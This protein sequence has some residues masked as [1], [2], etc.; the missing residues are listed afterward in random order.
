MLSTVVA[1]NAFAPPAGW[2]SEAVKSV[3]AHFDESP[4]HTCAKLG[5]TYNATWGVCGTWPGTDVWTSPCD[6]APLKGTAGCDTSASFDDRAA[7]LVAALHTDE[8]VALFSNGAGAV[9]RLNIPKYQWWSEA[10]HGVGRSPGVTFDATTPNATSFPQVITTASSWNT[11]L[12]HAIG[13]VVGTEARAFS[14]LG[15]AGLTFWAPNVNIFRDPRW[16][17][18]QETQGEDPTVNA[19]YAANF[20]HGVQDGDSYPK[21]LKASS[22]C[23]H[24]AAYNLEDWGGVDRHHF[25]AIVTD[26]DLNE[27]YFPPFQACAQVGK[28]SG[29]MCSYNAVNGVPSCASKPLL[30][31]RL[32]GTWGFDGYVTSDCGAV[33]DVY[34]K[35]K[36]TNTTDATDVDVLTAGMDSDCGTFLGQNLQA[37]ID[38]GTCDASV[39][40][41]PLTNLF[42][43]Q[44]RLGMFDSAASQPYTKLGMESVSTP[45]HQALALEAAQQ[46]IVL[47]KND[48]ATLPLPKASP[49]TLAVLGPTANATDVMQGNYYGNAPFVVSVVAGLQKYTKSVAYVSGC[50]D[51]KCADDS[52]F[53]G[54]VMTA[55]A[56]E[57]VVLVVGLNQGQESEGHDRTD[58]A[59]PGK[60]AELI[61]QVAAA[62]KDPITLV[63]LSG[64]P[65]DV[66]A[67]KANAKVGAIVWAGYPGQSGGDALAQIIFGDVN[68]SARLTQTWYPAAFAQQVSMFDMGMR[69]NAT[70]GNPGR[71]YRFYTGTPVFAF[72]EGMSYSTF[73]YDVDNAATEARADDLHR[74]SEATHDDLTAAAALPAVVD[75]SVAVTNTG[76]RAGAETLITY[77]TPPAGARGALKRYVATFARVRLGAGETQE[78]KLPLTAAHFRFAAADGAMVTPAGKWV[79]EIEGSASTRAEHRVVLK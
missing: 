53:D 49:P 50:A 72:G 17:R 10:L 35:H 56:A 62:A 46:G 37:C 9:P 40:N 14:N 29:V 4:E 36:Y 27:T 43:V 59:L 78:V 54:A 12:F 41:P 70:S 8:K 30:N 63:I 24:Y 23:K 74:A 32:R 66:S 21:Y 64:G 1:T 19:A 42:K 18:G 68:P 61:E 5:L 51:V 28:A 13:Q 73:T 6:Q 34:S 25:D 31:D 26:Q 52:G 15:H 11:S 45:A 2:L 33:A 3:K 67:A 38:D 71:G 16:G 48:G 65:V 22:C 79:V 75:L 47:L 76:G 39:V 58:L 69:P 77:V 44:L 20:P 60:Q 7:A 55:K 57:A